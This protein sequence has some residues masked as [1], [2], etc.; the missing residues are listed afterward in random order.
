MTTIKVLIKNQ[1]PSKPIGLANYMRHIISSRDEEKMDEVSVKFPFNEGMHT[2]A[3]ANVLISEGLWRF[4][5]EKARLKAKRDS[6]KNH[7]LSLEAEL[8]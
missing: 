8:S 2:N 6:L 4:I 3:R 1:F 5:D 7:I